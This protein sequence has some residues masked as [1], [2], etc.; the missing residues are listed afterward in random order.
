MYEDIKNRYC[1]RSLLTVKSS[2]LTK[3][4]GA[5]GRSLRRVLQG[6]SYEEREVEMAMLLIQVNALKREYTKWTVNRNTS[7]ETEL[8]CSL[9]Q[10]HFPEF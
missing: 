9:R 3:V 4:F 10:R 2:F 7:P 8:T 1:Y 5:W 6:P